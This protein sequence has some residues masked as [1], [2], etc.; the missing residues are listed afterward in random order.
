MTAQTV[1]E[2]PEGTD[3]NPTT[4][5]GPE[6]VT[7]RQ[8]DA[9]RMRQTSGT[10]AH[11]TLPFGHRCG[12]RWSGLGTAHCARCCNTFSGVSAFDDHRKD[13]ACL[14]PATVGLSILDGRAYQC[15]GK[16]QTI[17][18]TEETR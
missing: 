5:S 16:P 10:R 2:A 1:Q 8:R 14:D 13:G 4:E 9:E 3:P 15:W 17:E 12:A 7:A 6:A 11:D 18:T